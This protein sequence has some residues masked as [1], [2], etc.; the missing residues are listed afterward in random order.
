MSIRSASPCKSLCTYIGG[1]LKEYFNILMALFTMAFISLPV[2]ECCSRSSTEAEHRSLAHATAE[3]LW[4][5]S[6]LTELHISLVDSPVL[7]CDNMSTIALSANPVQ[8]SKTE[9]FELDLYFVRE[10]VISNTLFVRH[11]SSCDQVA[12]VLTKPLS[13]AVSFNKFRSK[14]SVA[15]NPLLSL[16]GQVK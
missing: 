10:K 2:L 6:L 16:R 12:D 13:G 9:H 4:I 3:F 11:V 5:R 15:L 14:L 7:W 1:L 8:H